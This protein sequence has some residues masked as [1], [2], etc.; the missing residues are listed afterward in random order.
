MLVNPS[1]LK[2]QITTIQDSKHKRKT[3]V[4]PE[5]LSKLGELKTRIT[6]IEKTINSKRAAII[7]GNELLRKK[8]DYNNHKT[9]L[10]TQK[11]RNIATT[12]QPEIRNLEKTIKIQ[13][14]KNN[15]LEILLLNAQLVNP[16]KLKVQITTI[17]DSKHKRKT[18]VSPEKLSKLGELKTRITAIE[19][20]INSKRAAIIKGNELL[21]KKNDYNNHKTLLLTQKKR[22]IATTLQPEIRNLEKTIKIQTTK[23][24][25]LEILLLNAQV[26]LLKELSDAIG[27]T[28]LENQNNHL[29]YPVKIEQKSNNSIHTSTRNRENTKN[30][31]FD[32]APLQIN[33]QNKITTIHGFELPIDEPWID[34]KV[35]HVNA[36]MEMFIRIS[37]IVYVYTAKFPPFKVTVK[38]GKYYILSSWSKSNTKYFP[39]AIIHGHQDL[40]EFI[41]GLA[42]FLYNL[43]YNSSLSNIQV[44]IT[45]TL[46]IA[47]VLQSLISAHVNNEVVSQK[48]KSSI[49]FLPI[50]DA[51]TVLLYGGKSLEYKNQHSLQK[52]L[53]D[54]NI[55]NDGEKLGTDESWDFV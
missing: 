9:L 55:W 1:K 30:P 42:M 46:N 53:A 38:E 34:L 14:T 24:N 2:V 13:T 10:L 44:P 17:Q 35:E 8:N 47:S 3:T 23:N 33:F 4:S 25:D 48:P 45:G 36:M 18:T 39:L 51:A 49:E 21:R 29:M 32:E 12:L 40:S 7:K 43:V 37:E 27:I 5:K 50:V 26:T 19:K 28:I 22:N 16:S 54:D 11:K 6:A 52:S 15:D 31:E 20:T 41:V